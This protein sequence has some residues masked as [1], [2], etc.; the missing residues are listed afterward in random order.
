VKGGTYRIHLRRWPRESGLALGAGIDD[1]IPASKYVEGR[2]NGKGLKFTQ[3]HLKIGAQELQKSVDNGQE[4]TIFEVEVPQG[5]TELIAYFD[6]DNTTQLNAY[7][8]DVE[9]LDL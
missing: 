7:Y 1:E 6:L 3:A 9:K 2:V 4:S 5:E 8:I